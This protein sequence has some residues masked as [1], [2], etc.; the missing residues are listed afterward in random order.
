MYKIIRKVQAKERSVGE[1]KSVLDYV[2]KEISPAV[3]FVIVKNTGDWGESITR[4]S[5]VYFVLE[6][7]LKLKFQDEEVALEPW[8]GCFIDKGTKYNFS[9]DCQIIVVD[10]P[11]YGS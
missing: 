3:S 10:S 11:A 6:G 2:T 8:D 9:G 5:R 4:Y 7:T 1:A